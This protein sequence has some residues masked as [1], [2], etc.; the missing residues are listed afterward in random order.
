MRGLRRWAYALLFLALWVVSCVACVPGP[1]APERVVPTV[2]RLD[3]PDGYG[4]GSGVRVGAEEVLTAA[5][6][7]EC[8]PGSK[9]EV[10]RD[11]G[12]VAKA[13]EDETP[14]FRAPV[15]GERVECWGYP[16]DPGHEG[17]RG[18][19]VTTGVVANI[20][21]ANGGP[22]GVQITCPVAPGMSGGPVIGA[23]GAV[24]GLV[25]SG[26]VDPLGLGLM[27]DG[28]AFMEPAPFDRDAATQE[29]TASP[30]E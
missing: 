7:A 18:L 4:W 25:V 5:H 29:P 16:S 14:T 1:A 15:L 8:F 21:A 26:Y 10:L 27:R 11:V 13:G 2:V 23:D 28:W 24:V 19:T 30:T 3:C 20:E 22:E 12:W 17:T 6:V 9:S